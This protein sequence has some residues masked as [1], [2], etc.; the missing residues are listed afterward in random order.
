[1]STA[2]PE[3]KFIRTKTLFIGG[4]KPHLSKKEI[5]QYFTKYG[6][7]L[8]IN[9]KINMQSGCNKGY[10]FV[11]FKNP[12]IIDRILLNSHFID[13]RQV[14][15]KIS[16]GGC[17]NHHDRKISAQCK[18]FVKKLDQSITSQELEEYFKSYGEVKNAYIILHPD[19]NISRGFG[20]VQFMTTKP[21]EKILQL[22]HT[23]KNTEIQCLKFE[24]YEKREEVEKGHQNPRNQNGKKCSK[25]GGNKAQQQKQQILPQQQ[26]AGGSCREGHQN[27]SHGTDVTRAY[28]EGFESCFKLMNSSTN[29]NDLAQNSINFQKKS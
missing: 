1:M 14:E 25:S 6:D 16:Y 22:K 4:L 15:C 26:Y 2:E 8:D 24:L 3:D 5:G 21:I 12:E 27:N 11:K 13:G 17:H 20:Y 9:I 19:T 29:N 10:A 7:I 18:I 23:I 28:T